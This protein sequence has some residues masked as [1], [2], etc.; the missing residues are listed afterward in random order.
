MPVADRSR[1]ESPTE[2]SIDDTRQTTSPARGPRRRRRP[3]RRGRGA[4]DGCGRKARRRERSS[5]RARIAR[6][7]RAAQR[8][9]Q[10][11]RHPPQ[12]R[13]A[14]AHAGAARHRRARAGNAGAPV[15]VYGELTTPGATRTLLFYAH[16]DGQPVGPEAWATP[17]FEPMLRAGRFEDEAPDHPVG[18]G[19]RT[20]WPT[21][22]ASTRARPATT[23]RRSWPCSR[24]STRCAPPSMPLSANLKFFLE[25]EEEAGSPNLARTLAVHRDLL[26]LRSLDLRRRPDRS[27]RAAARRAGR[28]RRH[29]LP[30]HRLRAGDEPAFRPL[31]Q[32]RA[33]S[34]RAPGASDRLDARRRRPHH[35]RRLRGA[36]EPSRRARALARDGVRHA[37]H[38]ARAA[39]AATECG[40]A[41]GEVRAAPVAQRDAAALRRRG[42]AAQRD[43][44]RSDRRL[45]CPPRAGHD[46]G[47]CARGDRGA[48]R[49]Q[50]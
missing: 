42:P 44:R 10:P 49:R 18:G 38:A 37:E 17:P 19:E 14:R 12:R 34:R 47:G 46:V 15:S 13:R 28:A 45:R 25:G 22:R 3:G 33:Q 21:R 2:E 43:R 48:C 4:G 1:L 6:S 5:D 8:R 36:G 7:A 20:R 27:A 29:Q 24:R 26:A 50:G 30:P 40:L 32:R 9:V 35:H 11:G 39:I 23:R 16:F 41:Y 31:R